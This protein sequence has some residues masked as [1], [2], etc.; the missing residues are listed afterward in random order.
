MGFPRQE[1]WRGLPF[2]SLGDLPNPGIEPLSPALAGR[3]FPTEPL[4]KSHVS[5]YP[6]SKL[7]TLPQ[8]TREG[9]GYTYDFSVIYSTHHVPGLPCPRLYRHSSH[10]GHQCGLLKLPGYLMLQFAPCFQKSFP[11]RLLGMVTSCLPLVFAGGSS[12]V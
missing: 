2:L 9:M 8:Q 11:P 1:F 7:H 6:P 5:V 10:C 3:F 4:G 12:A